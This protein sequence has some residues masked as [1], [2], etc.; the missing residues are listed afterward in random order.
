MAIYSLIQSSNTSKYGETKCYDHFTN[1]KNRIEVVREIHERAEFK[2][3]EV[4]YGRAGYICS[5]GNLIFLFNKIKSRDNL[6]KF[7]Y[8]EEIKDGIYRMNLMKMFKQ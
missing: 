3:N 6:E 8:S 7:G 2:D 1:F 4:L 5:I